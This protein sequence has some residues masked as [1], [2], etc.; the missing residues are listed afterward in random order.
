MDDLL[1]TLRTTT[2]GFS[3][4]MVSKWEALPDMVSV[5]VGVTTILYLIVKIRLTI[6]ELSYAP[7]RKKRKKSPRYPR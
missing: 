4:H 7:K 2:V 5:A 3:G 6:K 1:D